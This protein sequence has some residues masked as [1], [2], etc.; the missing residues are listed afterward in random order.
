MDS[1]KAYNNRIII[2]FNEREYSQLISNLNSQKYVN[3]T[4]F[5]HETNS[6]NN[7]NNNNSQKN[8]TKIFQIYQSREFFK[9]YGIICDQKI[10]QFFDKNKGKNDKKLLIEIVEGSFKPHLFINNKDDYKLTISE[11]YFNS[12]TSDYNLILDDYVVIGKNHGIKT[13]KKQKQYIN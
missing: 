2:D 4:F 3:N 6:N 11:D 13:N 10:S 8:N 9:S 12:N 1:N 7:Y 5:A